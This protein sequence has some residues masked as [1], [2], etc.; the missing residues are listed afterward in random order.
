MR[1]YVIVFVTLLFM[2]ALTVFISFVH[3]GRWN[4]VVA[5]TIAVTKALLVLIYF[6]HLRHSPVLTRLSVAAGVF[7]L[8]TLITL[9]M[10]DVLTRGWLGVPTGYVEA[11]TPVGSLGAAPEPASP[12]VRTRP[13]QGQESAAPH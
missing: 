6:M 8:V 10:S 11:S 2:T 12:D 3:L 7:W 13:G 5:L 1:T 9:T 4:D